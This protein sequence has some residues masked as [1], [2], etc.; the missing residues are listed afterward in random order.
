MRSKPDP[1]SE[2][3]SALTVAAR[4]TRTIG[5]GTPHEHSEPVDFGENACF[6]LTAV[7]ANIGGM[8]RL[9]SG[10][11]GSWEADYARQI[12]L[13]IAGDSVEDLLR[14]RSGEPPAEPNPTS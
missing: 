7:A 9:L 1:F 13:S 10:R 2:A 6:V 5:A 12:V 11:P 3:I 14:W 4:G 8:E